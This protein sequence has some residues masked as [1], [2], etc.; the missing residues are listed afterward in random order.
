MEPFDF[1]ALLV[2]VVGVPESMA[3]RERQEAARNIRSAI[4]TLEAGGDESVRRWIADVVEGHCVKAI[5]DY[6][7]DSKTAV[8]INQQTGEA[9]VSSKFIGTKDRDVHGVTTRMVQLDMWQRAS[10]A[11]FREYVHSM[12]FLHARDARRLAPFQQALEIVAESNSPDTVSMEEALAAAGYS[13]TDFDIGD[14]V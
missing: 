8:L 4:F 3:V 6:I 13:Y 12:E 2:E 1:H 14:V 11:A 9:V 5:R 7:R 10:V